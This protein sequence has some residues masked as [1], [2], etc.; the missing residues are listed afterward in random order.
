MTW[1]EIAWSVLLGIATVRALLTAWRKQGEGDFDGQVT[2]EE[3][4]LLAEDEV[5]WWLAFVINGLLLSVGIIALFTANESGSSEAATWESIY[6]I[7]V[8][9]AF[10][11]LLNVRIEMHGYYYRRRNGINLLGHPRSPRRR[12]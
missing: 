11:V 6:T 1:V 12:P 8:F 5:H 7:Y 3:R 9:L 2:G 4:L 10:A